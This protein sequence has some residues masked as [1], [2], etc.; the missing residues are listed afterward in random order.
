[1]TLSCFEIRKQLDDCLGTTTLPEPLQIHLTG[2]PD[3]Q[4]Y[5]QKENAPEQQAFHQALVSAV[6]S[7]PVLAPLP[8]NF[9]EQVEARLHEKIPQPQKAK[10]LRQVFSSP[11]ARSSIAAG[12]LLLVFASTAWQSNIHNNPDAHFQPEGRVS[13]QPKI[14]SGLERIGSPSQLPSGSGSAETGGSGGALGDS[15][16]WQELEAEVS[17]EED[18]LAMVVGF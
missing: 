18:P 5:W 11:A 8:E 6:Q 9:I 13:Q 7:L 16:F 4:S 3:C 12:V 17:S 2:C 14:V 10:A 15:P 1:M